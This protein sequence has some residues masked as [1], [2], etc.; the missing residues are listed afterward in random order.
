M[1][2][3][4]RKACE[5]GP[6]EGAIACF[7][8]NTTS[9]VIDLLATNIA[10]YVTNGEFVT[11]TIDPGTSMC[12]KFSTDPSA[13]VNENAVSGAQQGVYIG[14]TSNVNSPTPTARFLIPRINGVPCRNFVGQANATAEVRLHGSSENRI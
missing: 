11:M 8:I 12:Y 13:I 9:T 4:Q 2:I 7:L 14:I 1:E 5:T 6:A 10:A 3:E